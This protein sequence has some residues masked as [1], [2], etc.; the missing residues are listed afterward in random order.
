M[1]EHQDGARV[2]TESYRPPAHFAPD[3]FFHNQL[4]K[5]RLTSDFPFN[6]IYRDLKKF[7]PG[8]RGTVVDVGAGQSPYKHLLDTN[9]AQYVGLDIRGADNFGYNNPEI[10]HF[11]GR[12]IPL[13][14]EST[15]ALLCTKVL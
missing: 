5:A 11:D 10:V 15:D 1:S 3:T 9:V 6:T 12:H 4:F 2:V 14:S 13:D 7:L 8:V